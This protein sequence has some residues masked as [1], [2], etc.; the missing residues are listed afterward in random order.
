MKNIHIF[1]L[2]LYIIYTTN[3]QKSIILLNIPVDIIE[4]CGGSRQLIKTFNRLGC[5]SSPDTHYMFVTSQAEQQR[6]IDIWS[7]LS[8]TSFTIASVDNFNMLQTHS[9][10]H[11]GNHH[12]SY[13]G[14]TVQLVQESHSCSC[15]HFFN[16]IVSS[17]SRTNSVTSIVT[18]EQL[19]AILQDLNS[20]RCHSTNACP[21]KHGTK[22][23]QN[24]FMPQAVFHTCASITTNVVSLLS[25][26][27][28]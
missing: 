3:T 16:S 9:A 26:Q 18:S 14:T 6:E 13:H 7:Q 19:V 2:T 23:A 17:Y 28:R 1:F 11:S 8:P 27:L 4:V 21:H 15:F 20:S 10:V 22:K 12:R 25:T 5:T 24:G